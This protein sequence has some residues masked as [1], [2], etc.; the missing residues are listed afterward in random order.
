MHC[1]RKTVEFHCWHLFCYWGEPVCLLWH[2]SLGEQ[3]WRNQY[4]IVYSV[5][6][7]SSSS[8]WEWEFLPRNLGLQRQLRARENKFLHMGWVWPGCQGLVGCLSCVSC[9][10]EP[11]FFNVYQGMEE[12]SKRCVWGA[13][14]CAEYSTFITSLNS[15]RQWLSSCSPHFLDGAAELYGEI[16]LL[17][18]PVLGND[19][20]LESSLCDL[21][22]S[23]SFLSSVSGIP[24]NA[25]LCR[26]SI[27][28]DCLK[29]Q[30]GGSVYWD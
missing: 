1:T 3:P 8:L 14:C 4:L 19:N 27:F 28:R 24:G 22:S 9:L 15:V 26:R 23:L 10:W 21:Y 17:E 18:V 25:E 12:E 6:D 29:S 11:A 7:F 20:V 13:I 30:C 5:Y 16:N 2:Y